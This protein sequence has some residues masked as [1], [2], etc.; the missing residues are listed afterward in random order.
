ML[1]KSEVR[2]LI[3]KYCKQG[4]DFLNVIRGLFTFQ[5]GGLFPSVQALF[6]LRN[7]TALKSNLEVR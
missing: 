5:G 4:P 3:P 1:I 7:R 2:V 6:L